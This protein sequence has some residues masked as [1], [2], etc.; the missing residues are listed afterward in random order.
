LRVLVTAASGGVGV[1]TVQLAKLAGAYVVATCGTGNVDVVRGLGADEV[2]DYRKT[3]I[4]A[5]VAEDRQR[6]FDI[7]I[8]CVGKKVL[9]EC[10]TVVKE[11]GI[12]NRYAIACFSLPGCN[13]Y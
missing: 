12:L 13:M 11:G 4:A 2:L 5:W 3:D 7:V 9:E 8:D 6:E 10:W 1:W